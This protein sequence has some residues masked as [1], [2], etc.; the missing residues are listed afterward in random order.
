MTYFDDLT[1]YVTSEVKSDGSSVLCV[2]WLDAS[3]EFQAGG[4]ADDFRRKLLK[5]CV[6]KRVEKTRGFHICNLGSCESRGMWPPLTLTLGGKE[7][8]FGSA[9]IR[10]PGSV[11]V[12]Y[13]APD[14][15]HHYVVEHD[16]VPPREF[17]D[18]V[19]SM[20]SRKT[21]R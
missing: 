12:V 15:I 3:H 14:L 11:G 21:A 2:G 5:I 7:V 16:Y 8:V 4:T 6:K 9:E 13:A 19:L 1:P 17:I 18:A 10:V 20:K